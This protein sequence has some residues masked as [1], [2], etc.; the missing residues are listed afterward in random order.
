MDPSFTSNQPYILSE[1][2]KTII[3][4]CNGEI[5]NFRELIDIYKLPITSNSDCMTIP[6]LYL[7]FT[8]KGETTNVKDFFNLF[9]EI[10]IA[11]GKNSTKANMFSIEQRSNWIKDVFKN[12][13]RVKVEWYE[14]L[15]IAYCKSQ[16]ARYILRGLRTSADFGFERG[17]AQ[18]NKAMDDTLET[19]FILALPEHSAISS[20]I[21]RDI[22]KNGGNAA[23]FVPKE[24]NLK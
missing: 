6:E 10:I 12:E 24:V 19:I 20:T 16:N 2:E 17:I 13:P 5:Y 18:V 22:V 21:I 1:N 23:Q 4:I 7:K 3:F 15:T 11:I 8:R 14:G 9:D